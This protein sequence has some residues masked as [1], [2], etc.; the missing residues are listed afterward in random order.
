MRSV[1]VR[2]VLSIP[3]ATLCV[4][5]SSALTGEG[6]VSPAEWKKLNVGGGRPIASGHYEA[7]VM[8]NV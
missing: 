2:T 6:E 4:S 7:E 5:L 3:R 1:T 8:S